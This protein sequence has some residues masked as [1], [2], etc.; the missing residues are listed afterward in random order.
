LCRVGR[1][2]VDC[3]KLEFFLH[4]SHV[5]SKTEYTCTPNEGNAANDS[6]TQ[7][8]INRAAIKEFLKRLNA[9]VVAKGGHF[10]YSQ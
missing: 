9:C 7:G 2:A 5:T 8:T 3:F 4:L 6:L 10:H 1:D